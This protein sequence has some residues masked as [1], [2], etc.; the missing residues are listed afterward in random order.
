[1]VD[2]LV[3]DVLG[4]HSDADFHGST[5]GAVHSGQKDDQLA[6][7]DGLEEHHLVDG[8]GN[9][10]RPP[11]TAGAGIGDF[12]QILQQGAAVHIAGKIGF[13]RRQY[14]SIGLESHQIHIR[15]L[16]A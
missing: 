9:D 10:I 2:Q 14:F 1:M 11:V 4:D 6:H 3:P 15:R 5:A 13:V 12:I 8:Q 16:G 7:V